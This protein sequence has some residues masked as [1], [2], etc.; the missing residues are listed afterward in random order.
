MIKSLLAIIAD[1]FWLIVRGRK[2]KDANQV[3]DAVNQ[4]R[5]DAASGNDASLAADLAAARDRMLDNQ[6]GANKQ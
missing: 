4:A 5:K 3:P 6:G 1:I 2:I